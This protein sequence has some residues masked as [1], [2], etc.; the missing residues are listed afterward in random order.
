MPTSTKIIVDVTLK[1]INTGLT[2][3]YNLTNSGYAS[4]YEWAK[5]IVE[6]FF[7]NIKTRKTTANNWLRTN[8]QGIKNNCLEVF[9]TVKIK[10][11]QITP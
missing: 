2:G 8:I 5:F 7:V 9:I 6:K 1:A 4:R 10:L 11:K 3:L